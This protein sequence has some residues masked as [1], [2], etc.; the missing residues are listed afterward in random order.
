MDERLKKALE[1]SNYMVTLNDQ[2]QVLK[3]KFYENLVFYTNGSKFLITKELINFVSFLVNSGNDADVV[4][5]DDNDVPTKIDDLSKFLDDILEMYFTASNSYLN[6]FSKLKTSR[7]I[8][9]LT[10]YYD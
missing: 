7:S 5:I 10:D 4:L 9:K 6:E 2:K 3:T 1:F 8:E